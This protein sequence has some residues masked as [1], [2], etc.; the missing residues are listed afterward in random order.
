[1]ITCSNGEILSYAVSK[2]V[3]LFNDGIVAEISRKRR[4]LNTLQFVTKR[5]PSGISHKNIVTA[6]RTATLH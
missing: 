2:A 6:E 3:K 5:S 4:K 1:M